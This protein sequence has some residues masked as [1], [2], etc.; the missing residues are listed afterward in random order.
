MTTARQVINEVIRYFDDIRKQYPD[1]TND[2]LDT[3]GAI[4]YMNGNDGTDFDWD[5]NDR[6]CEFYVF[7]KNEYGF[8]K[9]LVSK[10]GEMSAYVYLDNGFASAIEVEPRYLYADDVED[11]CKVLYRN[12]DCESI[13]D[14]PIDNIDFE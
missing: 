10:N 12:A 1:I 11:L 9:V 2:M 8:I 13:W 7:H 4:H 3:N 14:E 6:L 5:V